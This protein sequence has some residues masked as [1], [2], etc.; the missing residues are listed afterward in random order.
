MKLLHH[1]GHKSVQIAFNINDK[2]LQG[3]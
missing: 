1:N 2:I 3:A